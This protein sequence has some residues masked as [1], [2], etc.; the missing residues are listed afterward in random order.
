MDYVVPPLVAA[1]S[2]EPETEI[3][4][5]MLESLADCA[6]V[7]GELISQHITAMIEQ[8]QKTLSN[9]LERRAERNKRANDEGARF[10]GFPNPDTLF[11]DLYGVQSRTSYH[12]NKCTTVQDCL[13]TV[14]KSPN[15]RLGTDTFGYFSR[16]DFDAEEHEALQD[17][18]AAEDEVFDQFAECVGSLLRSLNAPVLPLIEPLLAQ[19]VAPMLSPDRSPEERRI[20]VCVFDDVFE[21]ASAG[22][23]SLRYLDGFVGPC[24]A[25]CDDPDCD[26]RQA[27]VYGVGVMAAAVGTHFANHVPRALQA[28]AKVIQAP[29]ARSEEVSISP[30][31]THRL[32]DCPYKTDTFL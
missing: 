28:L 12:Y 6:G 26:V 14:H 25:G 3:Q 13:R 20:A 27:S 24:F 5:A 1:L 18:Q 7:A 30:F 31:T 8:F 17:E 16:P 19:Y 22:G 15:T 23:A 10:E 32:P 9:S 29:D 2:K 11:G 21:H 4:A